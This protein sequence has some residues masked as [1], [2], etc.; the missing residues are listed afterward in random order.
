[1]PS[2]GR[3][4]LL[5]TGIAYIIRGTFVL[6]TTLLVPVI[7]GASPTSIVTIIFNGYLLVAGIMGI[8]HRNNREKA[9]M[10]M[11]LG[12]IALISD[13]IALIAGGFYAFTIPVVLFLAIPICYIVGAYKNKAT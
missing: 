5:V 9:T 1:M 3:I 4:L 10:L 2:T 12:I 11:V 6:I 8:V 13:A 7:F